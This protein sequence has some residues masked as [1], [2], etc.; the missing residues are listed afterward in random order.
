MG[1]LRRECLDWLVIVSE[2]HLA[3]VLRE[4][5]AHYNEERPHRS[6]E[7]RPPSARGDPALAS[8]AAVNRKVRLGGLL[9]DYKYAHAAA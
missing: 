5:L 1:S 8:T 7:L 2:H 6:R 3:A 4:Y 9:S